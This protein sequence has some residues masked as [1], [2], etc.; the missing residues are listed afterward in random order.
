LAALDPVRLLNEI[1]E[2]QRVLAQLEVGVAH[3]EMAQSSPELSGFVASL[4]TVWRDGEVRATHRKRTIGPRT[5]RTRVDPFEAVWPQVHQWL[6][7]RPDANAK[8]LFL[9]L[10]ECMPGAFPPG[11]LRTLQRRVKQWR[12]EIARQLVFGVDPAREDETCSAIVGADSRNGNELAQGA[13]A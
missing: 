7:E 8:D 5:Y 4:A 3:A 1:R 11:Q 2:A 13:S 10:Q 9:R 12:S 6:N